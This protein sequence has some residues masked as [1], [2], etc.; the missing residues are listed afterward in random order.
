MGSP[1]ATVAKAQQ[2]AVSSGQEK[3]RGD[4][5]QGTGNSRQG[6]EAD[7]SGQWAGQTGESGK[8]KGESGVA[9]GDL[10]QG[11]AVGKRKDEGKT[12]RKGA[13]TQRRT[14][15]LVRLSVGGKG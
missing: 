4:R 3:C 2:W 5:L 11:S 13:K 6:A 15:S 12:S 10:R 1:S 8:E 14:K 7:G 9:F